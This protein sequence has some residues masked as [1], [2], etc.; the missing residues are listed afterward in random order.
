M[1]ALQFQVFYRN[2]SLSHT[3]LQVFIIFYC[4]LSAG[5]FFNFNNYL[6]QLTG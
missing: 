1:S 2:L 3:Y 6:N 5:H 4:L